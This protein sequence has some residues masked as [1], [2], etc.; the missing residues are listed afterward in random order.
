MRDHNQEYAD[1]Q[2]RRY[3][4]GFDSIVRGYLLDAVERFIPRDGTSLEMGSY[5]G[6]MTEQ[7]LN[8]VERVTVIEAASELASAVSIRFGNRITV[9]NSTFEEAEPGRTFDTVFLIHT[10]EHLDEPVQILRKA[11]SWLNETGSLIVAVPN[12]NAL[13]RQIA[14]K[15]G[16]IAHNTAITPGEWEHGHRRTY[17]LDLLLSHVRDAGLI[18]KDFGGVI[19]KPLA[20][21]QWDRALADGIISDDYVRAC[22]VLARVYPDLSASVYAVCGR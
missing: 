19:V 18:V 1:N 13:S 9:I 10:L 3:S 21:Y 8:R 6:D 11:A 15:M 20:N 4:Y 16:L 2:E 5:L 22:Q 12:A 7:I 14:V 17:T